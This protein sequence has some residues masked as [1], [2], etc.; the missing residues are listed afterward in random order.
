M[1]AAFKD[2]F[3][4]R[5]TDYARYR[6]TYPPALVHY[7]ASIAPTRRLAL[8]TGCGAGQ[9]STLLASEFEFV[10]ATDAS[11]QQIK[12]AKP[13]DRIEYRVA[14]A[15]ES[16]LPDAS[17]DLVCAAQAAHWFDLD[18]YYDEVRRVLR[19]GGVI[20]LVTYGVVETDGEAGHVLA[21]FY[22]NVIGRFWP[23]ERTLVETGYRSLPFPFIE[24]ATPKMAMTAH[25]SLDELLGFV[26]TWSAMRN[27]EAALGREP[28]ERF[29]EHLRA[30]WG[31]PAECHETRW[32]LSMR[33]GRV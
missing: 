17:A 8:D 28:Y 33:V 23:P 6:P 20:A 22:Y 32:P 31:D 16:A 1:A 4:A 21:D 12:N 7:L 9:L 5:S 29:A 30:A 27:A 3:S 13:H 25:W 2:H 11:P 24:Q 26:D 10:V 18:A 19:P 14:R 15:E